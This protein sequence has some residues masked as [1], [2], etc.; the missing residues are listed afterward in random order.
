MTFLT[1]AMLFFEGVLAFI[2]PC[3]LPMLPI[4]FI[5]LAGENNTGGNKKILLNT[6]SFVLGFTVVFVLLGA[7]AT[8][9]GKYLNEHR[10]IFQRISGFIIVIF[11]LNFMGAVKINFL[12]KDFR[13]G[14]NMDKKGVV[15]SFLFG[16]AFSFGWSACIGTFLGTALLTAGNSD[17]MYIGMLML[18]IF[19][20]GLGLP[21]ILTAVIFDS[22]K[23]FFSLIKKHY[24]I[25]NIIS[26]IFLIIIGILMITDTL[27]FYSGLFY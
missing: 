10:L 8:F 5:Y 4:Y 12:N 24:K 14:F 18:L 25:F 17:T 2:S 9:L 3:I 11:G 21:F 22:I 16:I 7:T 15:S 27:G 23:N 13:Y 26:G 1:A 19:S 20:L 6:I